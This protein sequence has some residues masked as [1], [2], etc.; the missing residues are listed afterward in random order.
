[1][2][3]HRISTDPR[4]SHPG[5]RTA[6]RSRL[7]WLA[8]AAIAAFAI[9]R[10]SVAAPVFALQTPRPLAKLDGLMI[11]AAA[12]S[13]SDA[14]AVGA[15]M[16]HWD[17]KTWQSVALPVAGSQLND[18]T[19]ITSND[20][21]A[22]GTGNG[23]TLAQHWDGNNW[24]VVAT[25]TPPGASPRFSSV[26]SHASNDVWIA[27]SQDSPVDPDAIVPLFEHWDGTSWTIVPSPE[28]N[29]EGFYFVNKISEESTSDIWA[30]GNNGSGP[31]ATPFFYHWNGTAW[32]QVSSP[33]LQFGGNLNGVVALSPTN[34]WAAGSANAKPIM[35]KSQ[36]ISANPIQTLIEHWDG[37][38]WSVVASPNFGPTAL[39]QSNHLMS[40]VALSPTDLWAVGRAFIPDGSGQQITFA[41]HGD[42]TSWTIQP[43][44]DVG[45]NNTLFGAAVALPSSVWF[46]GAGNFPNLE[47]GSGPLI[48]GTTGG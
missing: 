5:D 6:R 18:V 13:P 11:A 23:T 15:L 24:S 46:V 44:P 7:R 34:A 1:M 27:G 16:A 38:A 47:S 25:P 22:V 35:I 4:S 12:A 39:N 17:G 8:G 30:A 36:E 19:A 43:T 20:Y 2:S 26:T 41:L 9:S 32:S 28:P 10:P 33:A 37:K 40:V 21:W 31:S 3:D 14:W 42:G 48:A 29:P 45:S